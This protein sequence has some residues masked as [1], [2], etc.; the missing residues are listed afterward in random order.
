MAFQNSIAYDIAAGIPGE[1]YHGDN[2]RAV[3]VMPWALN[4]NG[5]AN[6]VGATWYTVLA[7]PILEAGAT[8]NGESSAYAQAGGTGPAAGLLVDPKVYATFGGTGGPLSPTMTL[9]DQTMA[10]LALG[11]SYWVT[12]PNAANIG[13]L[14]TYN[15]A[16]G[17]LGSVSYGSSF[18]GAISG[19]TLTA[20]AVGA[21]SLAIGQAI[22]GAGITAGTVITGL[23]TG[24]G[25]TGTY[26][27]NNTQTVASEAMNA[28]NATA[29]T[30]SAIIA[31]ATVFYYSPSAAGLAVIRL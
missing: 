10:Q 1:L 5:T 22:T 29:P 15:I 7:A 12:L 6:I 13:D 21:G 28:G 9:P 20:S 18:T 14:V 16:T 11:G 24:T 27:V 4:S 2:G 19:T 3:L 8:P 31:G 17:A 30:G 25:G 26:T 23:G